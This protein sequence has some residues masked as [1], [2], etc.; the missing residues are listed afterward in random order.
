MIT[1]RM[2]Q[3]VSLALP[4]T[5]LKAPDDKGRFYIVDKNGDRVGDIDIREAIF[6]IYEDYEYCEQVI[7]SLESQGEKV[8][9]MIAELE[10]NEH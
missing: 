8:I 6:T 2:I 10:K 1:M 9:D 7:E 3:K 5:H 4:N